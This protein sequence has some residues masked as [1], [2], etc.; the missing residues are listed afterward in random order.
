[1]EQN[2]LVALIVACAGGYAAWSLAPRALKRRMMVR[3]W[4]WSQAASRCPAWLRN[5]LA[6]AVYSSATPGH[7]CDA[8]AGRSRTAAAN[9]DVARKN[10]Q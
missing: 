6:R 10:P 5:R 2:V 3:A 9:T 4:S 1:V 8:C 7:A